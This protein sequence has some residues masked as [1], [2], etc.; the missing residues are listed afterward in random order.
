MIK[1]NPIVRFAALNKS[2]SGIRNGRMKTESVSNR[3][4]CGRTSSTTYIIS[5]T[6]SRGSWGKI[7]SFDVENRS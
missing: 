3:R 2:Q 6:H 1:L 5:I 4:H 7:R